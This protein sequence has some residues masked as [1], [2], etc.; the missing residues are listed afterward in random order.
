MANFFDVERHKCE[1]CESQLFEIVD[2][3]LLNKEKDKLVP[4]PYQKGMRCI[5]CG[6]IT[7]DHTNRL[8]IDN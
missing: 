7:M 5:A 4:E 2:I 6:K 1:D 8:A 3:C